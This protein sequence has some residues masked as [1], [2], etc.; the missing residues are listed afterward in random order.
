MFTEIFH[1]IGK[2]AILGRMAVMFLGSAGLVAW[3]CGTIFIDTSSGD[4]GKQKMNDA[5]ER[6]KREKT[7][8]LIFP[9]GHRNHS[10]GIEAF[11]KGAFY[12]AIQAQVPILPVVFSS[13]RAF[14]RSSEK[15]FGSGD[16]IIEALPEIPT[17]G[18][19]IEDIDWLMEKTRDLMIKKHEELNENIA[20]NIYLR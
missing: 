8:L 10:G 4:R 3:L 1:I 16:V 19:K 20:K 9:E 18:M 12:L 15:M 6:L 2:C 7:K 13:Y 5:M 17:K 11:K 14:M